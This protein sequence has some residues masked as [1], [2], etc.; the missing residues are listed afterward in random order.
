MVSMCA[1]NSDNPCLNF[2]VFAVNFVFGKNENK[3]KE[4]GVGPRYAFEAETK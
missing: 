3:Q 4:A 1:F 2:L